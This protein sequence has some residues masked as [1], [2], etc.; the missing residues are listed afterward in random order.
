M[1]FT[2]AMSRPSPDAKPTSPFSF[3]DNSQM[4]YLL[5]RDPMKEFFTL[6]CQSIKLNSPQMNAILTVDTQQLYN[7][8]VKMNIPFFKWSTWIEDF[9][10]KEFMR[11]CLRR[12]K[13]NG[14]TS[15]PTTKTFINAEHATK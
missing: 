15:K 12:T 8:A 7:K 10:N 6:T 2:E 5:N 14:M 3:K 13:R 4:E 9:L 11:V 1:E